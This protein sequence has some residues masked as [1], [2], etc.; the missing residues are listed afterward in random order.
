VLILIAQ[1]DSND[2]IAA[3]LT[4]SRDTVKTHVKRIFMKMGIHD[5]GRAIV[6][7]YESGLVRPGSERQ[8]NELFT[9]A[10]GDEPEL[11][12]APD[13]DV[14]PPERSFSSGPR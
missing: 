2:E 1:G 8:F 11:D 3:A 10:S 7:A 14:S 4:I 5:R 9:K 6:A 13:D 12:G